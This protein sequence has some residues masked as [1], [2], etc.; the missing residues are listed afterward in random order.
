MA[1]SK[2]QEQ[3]ETKDNVTAFKVLL[4]VVGCGS[5]E[6]ETILKNLDSDDQSAIVK[7]YEA[8]DVHKIH[9]ILGKKNKP[10]EEPKAE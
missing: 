5:Y 8:G 2:I 9:E 10:A 3:Q 1:K 4:R 7:A 6:A